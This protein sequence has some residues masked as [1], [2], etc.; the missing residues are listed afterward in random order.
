MRITKVSPILLSVAGPD[1]DP[2]LSFWPRSTCLVQIE[3]DAAVTG[4]GEVLAGMFVPEPSAALVRNY[5]SFLLGEDPLEIERLWQK[6][7]ARSLFWGRTGLS[8]SVLSGIECALWDIAGKAY[9]APVYRLLGGPAQ[10]R[11]RVYASLGPSL[12][13]IDKTLERVAR[14]LERGFTAF[15]LNVGYANRGPAATL[16]ELVR[17]ERAKLMALQKL[18]GD[19]ADMMLDACQGFCARS[20]SAKAAL[21]LVTALEEFELLWLEEPCGFGDLR[22]WCE[23]RRGTRTP[24]AGGEALTTVEEFERWL[25]AG[26]FDVAQPDAS[27]VG[28]ITHC[29]AVHQNARQ[30]SVRGT[31]HCYGTG[32]AMAANFHA[33]FASPNCPIAEFAALEHPLREELLEEPWRIEQGHLAPPEAPGLGV[34]LRE[35]TL[36]KHPYIPGSGVQIEFSLGPAL[37]L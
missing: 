16:K 21:Q 2:D 8:V 9:R 15:K 31:I 29:L 32:V 11:L 35:S 34:V 33:A 3:T 6:L 28:G 14:W 27:H 4:L 7:Y 25:D 18:A 30:R 17:E 10:E 13:P 22:G 26:A 19:G 1:E 20:W 24:V 37:L 12:W 5:A 23:V 36:Q